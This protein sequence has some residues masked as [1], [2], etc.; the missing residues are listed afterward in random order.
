MPFNNAVT[1]QWI[2]LDNSSS[3][4]TCWHFWKW[5]YH[6]LLNTDGCAG[7]L[8]EFW[9]CSFQPWFLWNHFVETSE[10]RVFLLLNSWETWFPLNVPVGCLQSLETLAFQAIKTSGYCLLYPLENWELCNSMKH[11]SLAPPFGPIFMILVPLLS[12]TIH[13]WMPKSLYVRQFKL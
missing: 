13:L 7:S 5:I 3:K 2:A 8:T 6:T 12:G 10:S 1:F 9:T 11:Q 4:R